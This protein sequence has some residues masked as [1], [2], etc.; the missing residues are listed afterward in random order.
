MPKRLALH[1]GSPTRDTFLPYGQQWIDN[2]DVKAVSDVLKT[3][4]ITQGPT[5][6]AFEQLIANYCNAKYAVAF[7]SGTAA[8]H[9]AA[10]AAGISYGN[11][12]ITTPL[13]FAAD[14]NCVL[15]QGGVVTFADVTTDTHNI[16]PQTIKQRITSKTKAIIPVDYAG[17]PCD[18]DD[19]NEIAQKHDLVVIEDAA[20]ALGS[21]YKKE[22]VGNLVDMTVLSFHPVKTITTG[23]GGMVLTN[24]E[25]YAKK[26]RLFHTHG[27]TKNPKQMIQNEGGW[28][29]EMQDLGYNYR[30][31]DFQCALGISQFN[32]L[33]RFIAR[34]R[35]IVAQYNK[36]FS[37][38]EELITP[39]EKEYVKAA[40]HLYTIQVKLQKLKT[41][42][43][44]LFE[45]LRAENIG[46]HVHYIPVHLHPY[47]QQRFGFK[48]GDY[49]V[50][51]AYYH[52][53]LTLPL[54]PK[55]S[56]ADVNDVIDAVKK[57]VGYYRT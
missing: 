33:D 24:N 43:K 53:C 46:V 6:T 57:V 34:R 1:G 39:I 36:A 7:S 54:F 23:E 11:E 50:A 42:R 44:T 28:Y 25:E 12:V 17:H 32:K 5:I 10:Y 29:Y 9:G 38:V 22:K 37:G 27:I 18:I 19:I 52:Q 31:T 8:L 56:D 13:T 40:Y 51:E 55:M 30:I 4:W 21:E 16:N 41:D 49:P 26:L 45:A 48:K 2:D 47:Y 15:F 3:D 20:H 35:E 14:A